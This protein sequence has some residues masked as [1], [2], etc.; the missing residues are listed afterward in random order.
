MAINSLRRDRYTA[1]E[2]YQQIMGRIGRGVLAGLAATLVLS[3]LELTRGMIPQL[4]TIRFLKN[5]AEVTAN[6]TGLHVLPMAGWLWHFT[7]G[8]LWWGALFGIMLPILPGHSPWI[9]GGAFG[10]IAGLLIMLM[11]MPLA[12]AGYFGMHLHWLDPVITMLYHVIYGVVLG[13]VY[14]FL[15]D[16]QQL[17]P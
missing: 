7:I 14:G 16:R 4:E 9:K 3:V 13:F 6:A 8:T 12:G 15:T 5:M 2:D 10:I 1:G 17:R 11:V